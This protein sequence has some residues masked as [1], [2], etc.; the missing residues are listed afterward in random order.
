M[1]VATLVITVNF[2]CGVVSND[3]DGRGDR[4]QS[5][6]SSLVRRTVLSPYR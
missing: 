2:E 4:P 3:P 1:S 6:L 5:A